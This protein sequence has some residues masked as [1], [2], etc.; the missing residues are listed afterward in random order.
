MNLPPSPSRKTEK[1]IKEGKFKNEI[2]PISVPQEKGADKIFDTD[3]H[4]RF[5][6]TPETLAK[7]KPA[8]R[9]GVRNR[10]ECLGHQRRRRGGTCGVKEETGRT[11]ACLGLQDR[12]IQSAA[13]DPAF[14]G[15]GPINACEALLARARLSVK[16]L[17][18]VEINEAF[19]AQ[20]LQVH[21]HMGWDMQK[22]NVLGSHCYR[23][24]CRCEWSKN[25]RDT[26]SR[27]ATARC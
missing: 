17:D 9:K 18:L 26:S 22:V 21:R 6:T 11:Q 19:A 16:D 12:G 7:L 10:R 14:M 3:E 20:S 25:P 4:P 23:A 13:L 8:F 15:L 24:S 27:D 5:G 2:V 1:A